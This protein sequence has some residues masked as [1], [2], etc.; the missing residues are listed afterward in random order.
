MRKLSCYIAFRGE[1]KR[2][3]WD[4]VLL[5]CVRYLPLC[6][7]LVV[8][9]AESASVPSHGEEMIHDVVTPRAAVT[10]S[11]RHVRQQGKLATQF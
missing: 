2:Q 6:L 7:Y 1:E 9:K 3:D 4:C 8:A 11:G 10:E 5:F